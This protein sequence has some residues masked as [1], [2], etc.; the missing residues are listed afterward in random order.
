MPES[1][2]NSETLIRALAYV[3]NQNE[4]QQAPST[5]PECIHPAPRI[6]PK[7]QGTQHTNENPYKARLRANI[8]IA[9]QNVNG[10]AAPS[11]N[12]NFREK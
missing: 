11:E 1:T 6:R 4:T 5:Q 7:N 9:S 3:R 2:L 10:A 8:H 12:M